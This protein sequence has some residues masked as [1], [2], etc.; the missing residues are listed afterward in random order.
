MNMRSHDDVTT[1]TVLKIIGFHAS[2]V[3][4]F[5]LTSIIHMS[6]V[7]QEL[8]TPDY[9]QLSEI[10]R[11][12]LIGTKIVKKRIGIINFVA[13]VTALYLY[14]RHN[15]FCEPGVYSLFSFLEYIVI[16]ANIVYHLQA[17][18]DLSEYSI[19]VTRFESAK[20]KINNNTKVE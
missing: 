3:G 14:D 16:V 4:I 8:V 19:F 18:H 6:L 20:D 5:L 1:N 17:Y 11:R 9:G 12:K 7:C 13:I 10:T 2:C 15:R